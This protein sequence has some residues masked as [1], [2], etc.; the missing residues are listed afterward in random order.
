[1][2]W[3]S[4]A[5]FK[6]L[7]SRKYGVTIWQSVKWILKITIFEYTHIIYKWW[8]L[9]ISPY[10]CSF[11]MDAFLH[12]LH[13]QKSLGHPARP[14]LDVP[15]WWFLEPEK[16]GWSEV[17]FF[18][19]K[20]LPSAG[21]FQRYQAWC[22]QA[23]DGNWIDVLAVPKEVRVLYFLENIVWATLHSL[24]LCHSFSWC[25]ISMYFHYWSHETVKH[26]SLFGGT[27]PFVIGSIESRFK[28]QVVKPL[29]QQLH[30]A[31]VPWQREAML[32]W[33]EQLS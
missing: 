21:P 2:N 19:P 18:G 15:N 9:H 26:Q 23:N 28:S 13:T 7:P 12:V 4:R 31:P 14:Q 27:T 1:M 17:I 25:S 20:L 8:I 16:L 24:I 22:L 33:R 32:R 6:L 5:D 3:V 29:F 10:P 30:V 11:T